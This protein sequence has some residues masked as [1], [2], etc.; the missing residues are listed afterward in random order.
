MKQLSLNGSWTL[1]KA[2]DPKAIAATVPGCVHTDLLANKLLENPFYRDNELQQMWVGRTDWA[3]SRTFDV[4]S[5]LLA[6]DR[7]LL[8]PVTYTN[9]AT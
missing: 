1:T 3:Y 7:V 6:N 4:P 5:D 2:G 9:R 8:R